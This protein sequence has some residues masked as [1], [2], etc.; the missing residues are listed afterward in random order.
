MNI[1]ATS[2]ELTG[3]TSYPLGL[4]MM[5]HRPIRSQMLKKKRG[6][7]DM[8]PELNTKQ[9][10]AGAVKFSHSDLLARVG[11]SQDRDAFATLFEALA[12]RVKA[13]MMKLGA[14][15]D[16]AEEITQE[17]FVKV[18]RKAAQYDPN[19]SSAATWAFTIARNVRIDTLRKENRPALDPNE[20]MLVPDEPQTPFQEIEKS[21]VVDR[22]TS[23]IAEMSVDQ[24]EVIQLSFMVGL[25]HQEIANRLQIPLGTVKS[26]LR[27]SFEKLRLSLGEMR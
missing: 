14:T 2:L 23:S 18:W 6:S 4:K 7:G 20:P 22:V 12:P 26:R 19:K 17:T 9:G 16:T 8:I 13:Y 24:R 11:T 5:F 10:D 3:Q 21:N 15:P 25:S 1:A 27:L